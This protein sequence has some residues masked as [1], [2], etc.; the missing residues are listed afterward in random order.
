MRSL[1]VP[2]PAKLNLFLHVTGRRA[3]GYHTLEIAVRGARLRRHAHARACATTA[4]S[5]AAATCPALPADDDLAVRA[6]RALQRGDRDAAG[7]RH[8]RRQ[9]HPAGRRAGR[10]QL[11]RG[12]GAARAQPA[13]GHGTCRATRCRGSALA[14]GADVPF[15]LGGDAGDRARHRRAPDAG[16]AAAAVGRRSGCPPVAVST[17][18]DLRGAGIDTKHRVGENGSLFRGLWPERSAAGRVG[19]V[20]GHRR[21][22]R[23][24]LRK[25]VAA[26]ADD[27]FG[28]L[29][30]RAVRVRSR[31]RA[32]GAGGAAARDATGSSRARSRGIRW[33]AFA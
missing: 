20:S 5:C 17:R 4:R 21:R 9:A 32:R 30:V 27:G 15:F 22:A 31:Q 24:G 16:H 14:L 26:R 23:R 8:R 3:D 11:R 2:A 19:A 6:A 18:V 13:L 29:C 10:R 28:R 1:T 12:V 33:P 25:H 7:R